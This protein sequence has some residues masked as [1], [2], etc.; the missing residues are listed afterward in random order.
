MYFNLITNQTIPTYNNET[1]N[2]QQ[3]T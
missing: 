3:P 1:T 2:P